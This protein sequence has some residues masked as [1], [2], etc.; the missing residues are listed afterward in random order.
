M[1]GVPPAYPWNSYP[2][3]DVRD[4]FAAVAPDPSDV[5]DLLGWEKDLKIG[6]GDEIGEAEWRDT[7]ISR[8]HELPMAKR[9][10][11]STRFA[12]LWADAMLAARKESPKP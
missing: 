1:D 12:Y 4:Y 3:V 2:G 5:C 7:M 6:D 8:W 10:L 11:V 9:L